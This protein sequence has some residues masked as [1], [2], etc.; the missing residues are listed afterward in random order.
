MN[1]RNVFR[2]ALSVML[3][4]L[5]ASSVG[6]GLARELQPMEPS[7]TVG[8]NADPAAYAPWF[9]IEVDTPGDVGLYPSVAID[10]FND[11]TYVSYYDATNGNLRL[12]RNRGFGSA[13]NCG[14]N[15]SWRCTT[16]DSGGDV[17]K[18]SSIAIKPV[19][20]G[21]IYYPEI[22]IT[23][24]DATNGKLKYAY[25]KLCPICSWSIDSID[26]PISFPADN[27]GRY[28]SLK[29]NSS[30]KPYIAYYF[31]ITSGVDSLMLASYVGDG[32]G[33]CANFSIVNWQC[34]TIKTGE[35]VGEYASLA[36]DGA[37][38]RH[39]AYYDR[40]NHEL[41]LAT[42]TSI[43]KNCGPGGN[44]WYCY[45]M[46]QNFKNAGQY[47]SLYVDKN[48]NF[49]IAYYDADNDN[50]R[51]AFDSGG[52][53]GPGNC[54]EIGSGQCVTIDDMQ[55]GYHPL[56]VSM[57]EGAAGYP[58]IAYQSQYGGLNL[59]RPVAALGLSGGGGNC[60]PEIPFSTWYCETID[61]YYQWVPARHGD[62][63]SIAINPS[64]L[65]TIAYYG[66]IT[67]TEGNLNVSYQRF[68]IYLPLVVKNQ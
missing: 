36:L 48:N 31:E 39:I 6:S 42:S 13:G 8:M 29:Y 5:A 24:Y 19:S 28:S 67:A 55:A 22:G 65:A 45:R 41:W 25:G 7:D 66:F 60:G 4:L 53:P 37:G 49:H 40:G 54:G 16:V 46:S 18:Y 20:G 21:G 59:A 50:L 1:V 15:N 23:Y 68:Q 12:A 58:I 32:S 3:L 61:R 38:N 26:E 44:T 14:P 52:G 51:Y 57:A 64:G 33:N 30:G 43:G 63:V 35:G 47:A 27:K 9:N 34:D 2:L 17:G 10:P 11:T 56:G 62:Y